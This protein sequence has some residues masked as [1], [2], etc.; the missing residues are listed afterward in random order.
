MVPQKKELVFWLINADSRQT[1]RIT[2]NL[3]CV[4]LSSVVYG[5]AGA[6]EVYA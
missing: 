6:S 5:E 2:E 1:G 3:H 4:C